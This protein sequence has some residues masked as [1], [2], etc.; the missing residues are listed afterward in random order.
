MTDPVAWRVHVETLPNFHVT[1]LQMDVMVDAL[2]ADPRVGAGA[3]SRDIE[4]ESVG[5]TVSVEGARQG[6]AIDQAV[7]AFYTALSAAGYDTDRPGW[8]LLLEAAPLFG[9]DD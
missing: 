6:F 8:T 9:E 3:V 2:E 1:E 7:S 5:T 4:R